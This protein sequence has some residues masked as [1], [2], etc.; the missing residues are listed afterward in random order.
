M[1]YSI[2]Y[3]VIF[4]YIISYVYNPF[5]I[6]H[7]HSSSFIYLLMSNF[8]NLSPLV[9]DKSWQT[10][11]MDRPLGLKPTH[12]QHAGKV[13]TSSKTAERRN[14]RR[15]PKTKALGIKSRLDSNCITLHVILFYTVYYT[16][17][18]YISLYTVHLDILIWIPSQ[19]A[20]QLDTTW[21]RRTNASYFN[22][23]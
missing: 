3:H 8:W 22:I 6:I 17:L 9:N 19:E 20:L 11:G 4:Y 23:Q 12:G 14:I 15:S 2:L 1:L 5:I 16:I 13:V 7:D 10:L 18:Y 21:I